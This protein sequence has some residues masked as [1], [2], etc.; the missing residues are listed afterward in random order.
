MIRQ[1]DADRYD[2]LA[3]VPPPKGARTSIFN[4]EDGLLY[5]A[6]P[7]RAERAEQEDPEV[8]VYRAT[9]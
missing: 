5:L 1:I 3:T 4:P 6:V 8:S 9:P 2:S 7:R